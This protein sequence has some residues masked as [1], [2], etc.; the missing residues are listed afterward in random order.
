[1]PTY[2]NTTITIRVTEP[3]DALKLGMVY[4]VHL[5]NSVGGTILVLHYADQDSADR[6]ASALSDALTAGLVGL[7]DPDPGTQPI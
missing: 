4:P 2:A 6:A 7:T 3:I 5:M 1:M